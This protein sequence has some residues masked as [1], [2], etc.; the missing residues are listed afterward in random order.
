MYLLVLVVLMIVLLATGIALGWS[1]GTRAGASAPATYTETV[2]TSTQPS[3]ASSNAVPYSLAVPEIVGNA[4]NSSGIMQPKFLVQASNGFLSSANISLPAHRMIQL[5]IVSYD[6]PTPNSTAAEGQVTGTVGGAV[7]LIN[8]TWASISNATMN[9]MSWGQNVT[10]VPANTLA[11]TFTIPQLGINIPVV[12]GSTVI[13]YLSFDKPGTYTWICL[14]PCG[15]GVNGLSGA[16][17]TA[18]WMSGSI[19]I[20]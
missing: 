12:G 13:A 11:H 6:T 8:G 7:Y 5:T 17:S 10:S 2:S 3:S 9:L 14:T 4:W 19:T 15:L 18:G 1:Y 16:M 20:H